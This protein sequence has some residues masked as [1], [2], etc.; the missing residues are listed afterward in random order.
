MLRAAT[1]VE[2]ASQIFGATYQPGHNLSRHRPLQ[3][4]DPVITARPGD[5]LICPR[6][7]IDLCLRSYWV[8]RSPPSRGQAKRGMTPENVIGLSRMLYFKESLHY[9]AVSRTSREMARLVG[10]E[11]TCDALTARSLTG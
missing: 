2:R 8:P 4:G 11:P 1:R 5:P 6:A 3:A 7:E 10:F 9:L